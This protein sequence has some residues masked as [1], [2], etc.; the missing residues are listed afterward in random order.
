MVTIGSQNGEDAERG[1]GDFVQSL[2]RGVA[3]IR[4]FDADHAVLSLSEV[5]TRAGIPRAAARR[6]LHTLEAMG[7]VRKRD[8]MFALTPRVLELGHSYLSSQ[9]FPEIVQPHLEKVSTKLGESVSAAVLDGS[10]V[11]YVARAAAQR[12]M[13]VNITVGTRFPAYA[14]SLG[15]ALV[16]HLP[17]DELEAM[18]AEYP[19]RRL[20]VK[21]VTDPGELETVLARVRE[22]GWALVD[23]ELEVGLRSIAVPIHAKTGEVIAAINCSLPASEPI[24]RLEG[25][26]APL[27]LE[28]ARDIEAELRLV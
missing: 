25:E 22:R 19:P 10:N 16:A 15:R 1:Q 24:S 23:E 8:K 26:C 13:S 12:I 11:V 20:T 17:K 27:L 21:T 18:L 5:A 28:T 9:S 6:F 14:T 3:V 7:Y 2:A 4:A